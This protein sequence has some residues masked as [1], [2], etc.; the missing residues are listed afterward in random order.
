MLVSLD[1]IKAYLGIDPLETEFDAFLTQ[2][3]Q[4]FSDV[5]ESY[6]GRKFLEDE[7]IE[8]MYAKD[9]EVF[10][11]QL[12]LF[13]YPVSTVAYVRIDDEDLT[14][15]RLQK[16]K[17]I[18]I[19]DSDWR[20]R[21]Q[22]EV[23]YTAGYQTLPSQIEHVLLTLVKQNFNLQQAGVETSFGANVQRVNIAGV[24]SLDFDYSL[25]SNKRSNAYGSL[26]G[27]YL[28]VLDL[29]RSERRVIG[30]GKL[31]FVEGA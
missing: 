16:E 6:C 19:N 30:N 9:V 11:R 24:M 7:Y 5:I 2:Q 12:K 15:Y 27:Q 14:E 13:H 3:G 22:I 31:E 18:L 17:G 29:F 26:L 23:R 20:V 28:N 25:E 8:T 21:D 1:D 4:L 10:P